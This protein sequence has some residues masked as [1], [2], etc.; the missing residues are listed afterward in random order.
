MVTKTNKIL[1]I[2]AKSLLKRHAAASQRKSDM[3][4]PF[5]MSA[6]RVADKK[7]SYE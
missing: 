7:D 5:Q 1:N 4:D 6:G 3:Q 2:D